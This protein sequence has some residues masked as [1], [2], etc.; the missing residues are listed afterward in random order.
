ML[1][2]PNEFDRLHKGKSV[3]ASS[4]LLKLKPFIGVDG[5]LRLEGRL[6]FSDLSFE[7]KHPI[8]LPRSHLAELIARR[9][10]LDLKHAGVPQMISAIR[11]QYWIIGIRKLARKV[12]NKCPRCVRFDSLPCRQPMAPLPRERSR[13]SDP[14]SVTGVDHAGPLFSADNPGK[15]HYICLFTCGVIRAI[16]LELVDDLSL[17]EFLLAFKRFVSRRRLPLTIFSDQA[18][19][20]K[21]AAKRLTE[22]YSDKSPVW[23]FNTPKCPWAG[24]MWERCVRTVKTSLRKCLGLRCLTKTELLTLLCEI[25]QCINSRPLTQVGDTIDSSEILTPNHFLNGGKVGC[26]TS[27]F[28]HSGNSEVVGIQHMAQK[29]DEELQRFWNVWSTEYIRQLPH[30]PVRKQRGKIKVGSVVLIKDDNSPKLRWPLGIVTKTM[31][32][33][34]N[35]V[36]SL[37]IRVQ[38][39]LLVR[40]IQHVHMLELDSNECKPDA[41]EKMPL[42]KGG[43]RDLL[44]GKQSLD[45]NEVIV[46]RAG[47]VVKPRNILDL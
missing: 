31:T 28:L 18:Q 27:I 9:E 45:K 34:D 26:R 21:A 41:S 12:K 10:H 13:R 15:K 22:M 25:E 6:H 35:V 1:H 8:V 17:T 30:A 46:T 43:D 39:G 14:F 5:L 16:H 37:E 20:F 11:D 24:G 7:S 47:R 3:A 42:T 44:V 19:T 40:P 4:R 32:S 2:F 36:R 23:K 33:K 38:R 29:R